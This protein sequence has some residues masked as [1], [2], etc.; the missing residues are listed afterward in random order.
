M[1]AAD[2]VGVNIRGHAQLYG[3]LFPQATADQHGRFTIKS[4]V[5]GEYRICAWEDVE[6]TAWMDAEFMKPLEG[7][8][9][10]L[11]VGESSQVVE[12]V[13]LIPAD[14]ELEKLR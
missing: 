6:P 12:Q 3:T 2:G 4:V 14:P 9:S 1:T 11:T 5:P 8:E 13:N 7:K 10:S